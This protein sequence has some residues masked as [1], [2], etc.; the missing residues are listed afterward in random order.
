MKQSIRNLG[1]IVYIFDIMGLLSVETG[2]WVEAKDL[3]V[4][5]VFF[6]SDGKLSTQTGLVRVEQ[7]GGIDVFQFLDRRKRELFRA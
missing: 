1:D 4:G 2:Y 7:S 5:D 3:R 6:G